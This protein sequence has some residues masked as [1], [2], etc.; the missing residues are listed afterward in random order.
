MS[1]SELVPRMQSEMHSEALS[2]VSRRRWP[3]NHT[4]SQAPVPARGK[5]W[6]AA[7]AGAMPLRCSAAR[8]AWRAARNVCCAA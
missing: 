5:L 6:R 1:G 3:G 8:S 2:P 4:V 7:P